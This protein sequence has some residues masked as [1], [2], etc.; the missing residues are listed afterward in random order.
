MVP[1]VAPNPFAGYN[2]LMKLGWRRLPRRMPWLRNLQ[3]SVRDTWVLLNEFKSTLIGFTLALLF[4]GWAYSTLSNAT[5][6][7]ISLAESTFLAL[8]MIFLQANTE[9]PAEWY[10]QIFFF[11][12]PVIGLAL[13][14]RGADFGVLLFNRR[15]RGEAWQV[16]VASNFSNHVVLIGLGHLGSRVTRE[17]NLLGEEVVVVDMAPDAG[18]LQ[19]VLALNIPVIQNDAT[20]PET[21]EAA[22]FTRARTLIICT[23]NDTL[24]LQIAIKARSL[25]SK[26]RILVRVFDEEF[27]E[28]IENQFGID[29]IFSASTLAAPA[30]AGAATQSDVSSPI[31]ISGRTLSLARVL[32]GESSKIAGMTIEQFENKFDVTV[33]L[34]ERGH[35]ADLHPHNDITLLAGDNIALFAEPK[36]LM[37]I[38]RQNR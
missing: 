5:G 32:L 19:Q 29:Q 24:N 26:A 37:A 12:M 35:K 14:A 8:G 20:K 6:H 11:I 28:Q 23:S 36:T 16:A 9:F 3:A 7:P 13:L 30:I 21:L 34:L 22:G 38:S 4:G 18:L 33:V 10:R 1:S 25:N 27:A 17:L 31:A 15:L 2:R